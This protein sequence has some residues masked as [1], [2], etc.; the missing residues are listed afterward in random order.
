MFGE[1][2][3]IVLLLAGIALLTVIL[4]RRSYRY[5][6]QRKRSEGPMVKM[7]RGGDKRQPLIDAPLDILR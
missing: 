7:P 2:T 1:H 3:S 6:G 4:L 5:F